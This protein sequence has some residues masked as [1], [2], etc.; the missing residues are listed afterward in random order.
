MD[1]VVGASDS[2]ILC[3][4]VMAVAGLYARTWVPGCA[5][6]M[7]APRSAMCIDTFML[8]I[9]Y[10]VAWYGVIFS[11]MTLRLSSVF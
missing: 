9:G 8:S 7:W 1:C 5:F 10:L 11:Y 3:Q 6:L 4:L 2:C